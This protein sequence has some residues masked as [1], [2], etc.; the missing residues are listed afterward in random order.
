[1]PLAWTLRLGPVVH[2]ESIPL[3]QLQDVRDRL[4]AAGDGGPAMERRRFTRGRGDEMLFSAARWF[5][6]ADDA[7]IVTKGGVVIEGGRAEIAYRAS[8]GAVLFLIGWFGLLIAGAIGVW[9]LPA[10]EPLALGLGLLAIIAGAAL[11]VRR[12]IRVEVGRLRGVALDAAMRLR[13]ERNPPGGALP[14]IE[15]SA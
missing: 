13:D 15:S 11:V 8:L 10:G 14:D 6:S 12:T 2:R 4:I 7:A 5:S 3:S 1:M 9:F